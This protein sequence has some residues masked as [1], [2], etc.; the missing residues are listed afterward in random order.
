MSYVWLVSESRFAFVG[1]S[2]DPVSRL[3]RVCLREEEQ[4]KRAVSEAERSRK[5]KVAAEVVGMDESTFIASAAYEKAR[6]I[7]AAQFVTVLSDAQFDAFAAAIDGPGK[8]TKHW[9]P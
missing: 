6:E 4:A 8:G 3:H 9:L 2:D 7:E 1:A 5:I